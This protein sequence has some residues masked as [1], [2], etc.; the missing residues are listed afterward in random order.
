MKQLAA[1]SGIVIYEQGSRVYI[2]KRP[3]P[4]TST[5][6]FVTGL[7]TIIL[8]ANAVFQLFAFNEA[9]GSAKA[10]MILIF[11][12]IFF[13]I[14]FWRVWLYH[15][16]IKDV[17]FNKLPIIAVIDLEKNNL[18]DSNLQVL[19]PLNQ[20]YL[21]RKMQLSSSSA[22]LIIR[23]KDGSLSLAKGNPFSGGVAP[24]ERVLLSKGIRKS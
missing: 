24:I 19:T 13:V 20:A 15:K 23:W 10:G 17:P 3:E 1:A 12:A 22:E 18:L 6:L 8:F 11:T 14:L 7:L 21:D 4:W 16:R 9:E 5:F 2:G